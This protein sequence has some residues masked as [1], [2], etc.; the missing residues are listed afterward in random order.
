MVQTVAK[1]PLSS[2]E[3]L[4]LSPFPALG[5]STKHWARFGYLGVFWVVPCSESRQF[6]R[7]SWY[8]DGDH[9]WP[10]MTGVW[11]TENPR[12]TTEGRLVQP[13]GPCTFL[14]MVAGS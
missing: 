12:G 14:E 3:T 4:S 13:R 6:G 7:Q 9:G 2:E 5:L 10:K 11:L 1:D 8:P